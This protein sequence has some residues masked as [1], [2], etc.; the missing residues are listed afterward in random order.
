MLTVT[1]LCQLKDVAINKVSRN[2]RENFRI[3]AMMVDSIY[4]YMYLIVW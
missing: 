1:F 3:I 4:R 2:F